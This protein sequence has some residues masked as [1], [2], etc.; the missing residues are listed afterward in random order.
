MAKHRAA[1]RTTKK[2]S[3][4]RR[5]AACLVCTVCG[6]RMPAGKLTAGKYVKHVQKFHLAKLY[7][8]AC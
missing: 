3:T 7:G 1:K 6:G 2:R 5:R 8:K 4:P